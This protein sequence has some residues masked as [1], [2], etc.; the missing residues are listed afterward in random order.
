MTS[1]SLT[2]PV[3]V[4]ITCTRTSSPL[5]LSIELRIASMLPT[6]SALITMFRSLTRPAAM[7]PETA[8]SVTA[9]VAPSASSRSRLSARSRASRSLSRTANVS[10]ERGTVF[11]PITSTGADGPAS[12]TRLPLSSNIALTL[13]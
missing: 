3:P 10:P 11:S 8:S 7:S 12:F 5:S 1:D 9:R 6:A 13:P 4:L 2:F